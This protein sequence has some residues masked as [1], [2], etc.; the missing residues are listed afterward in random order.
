MKKHPNY[1]KKQPE[2]KRKLRLVVSFPHIWICVM[3]LLIAVVSLIISCKLNTADK[4]FSSSVFSNIFAGLVTGLVICLISGVKQIYTVK[5]QEKKT[6]LENLSKMIGRYFEDYN[7]L[8][9]LHF[10][11]FNGDEELFDQIYDCGSHANWVND[12]I[13]QR[14]FS[15]TLS[16]NTISYCKKAFSY[17]ALEMCNA[18]EELHGNL[19]MVDVNCPSSKEIVKYFGFVDRKLRNL[20]MEIHKE[21]Q[22]LEI[23]LSEIHKSLV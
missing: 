17:Q 13:I 8:C 15:R 20:N 9:H 6:W 23:R 5:L 2:W 14:S 16:F 21:V 1:V 3:T 19:Q 11:E 18:F 7:A 12:E 22:S 10:D 4:T